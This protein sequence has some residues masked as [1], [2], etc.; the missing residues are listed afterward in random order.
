M[1]SIATRDSI[2]MRRRKEN[3][4]LGVLFTLGEVHHYRFTEIAPQFREICE[5][6]CPDTDVGSGW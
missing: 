3:K 5:G 4:E 2:E 1:S 6:G